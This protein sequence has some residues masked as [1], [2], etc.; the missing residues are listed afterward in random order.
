[1]KFSPRF[2]A[3]A[4]I[5]FL[6]AGTGCNTGIQAQ[7][8]PEILNAPPV[9]G[10]NIAPT[11]ESTGLTS[12]TTGIL[13]TGVLVNPHNGIGLK[14]Y[15]S[16]GQAIAELK[17]PGIDN[18]DLATVH[19]A[20]NMSSDKNFPP[21]VFCSWD[22]DQALRVNSV[23]SISTLRST[24]SFLAL[25]GAA[26]QDALAF[27]E[28][29]IEN[30]SPHSYLYAGNFDDLGNASS[31]YDLNDENTNMALIPVAVDAING[32]PQ[33]VWYTKTAWGIG[34]VDLIYPITS[35]LYYL[36]LNSGEIQQFLDS[37]RNFQGIS[38]DHLMAGS[39]EFDFDGDRS[40]MVTQFTSGQT[41][42]FQLNST[43]DRGAGFAVFS[44]DG[45]YIAW[46]EA[47]GSFSTDPTDFKARVRIGDLVG[48]SILREIT[49]TLIKQTL[50]RTDIS[51]TKP[52]GWL[53]SQSLLIEAWSEDWEQAFL[54]RLNVTDGSL[55][56]FCE[57]SFSGFVYP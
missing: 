30:N 48:K 21:I 53:D 34:G 31:V 49:S 32:N 33:G 11:L 55:T 39:V 22:P 51:F 14:Y 36:D 29:V 10:E 56:P 23:D 38:P 16:T 15:D 42:Q 25:V 47:G 9:E 7:A 28:V 37:Q 27:S 8:E 4:I 3:M 24:N 41:I 2:R 19:I 57:G 20:G 18:A 5:C 54:V 44:P 52:A 17:T 45:Q 13:P 12:Q 6:I 50:N 43:S 46:L 40:M 35:G 1:M 26:G